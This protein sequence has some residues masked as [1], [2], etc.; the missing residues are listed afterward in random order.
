MAS[1]TQPNDEEQVLAG[2]AGAGYGAIGTRTEWPAAMESDAPLGGSGFTYA[3][4]KCGGDASDS[5]VPYLVHEP[6]IIS[7][8]GRTKT[9]WVQATCG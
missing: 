4:N 5:L 8:G 3:V 6:S 9:N 1:R 2:D 7:G